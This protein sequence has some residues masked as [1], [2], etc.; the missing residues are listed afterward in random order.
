MTGDLVTVSLRAFRYL[1]RLYPPQFRSDYGD[2]ML[3]V[4]R[5]VVRDEYTQGGAP[6]LT[7]LWLRTVPDLVV[8]AADAHI[9]EGGMTLRLHLIRV[10]ALSGFA[11][12]ALLIAYSLIANLRSPG[13]VNGPHRDLD[14]MEGWFP[15]GLLL[16]A[17]CLLGVYARLS[18]HWPAR[19][20]LTCWLALAG[21]A[22]PWLWGLFRYDF[23]VFL[24][25]YFLMSGGVLLTGVLMVRQQG[26]QRFAW[27]LSG[28]GVS[29]LLF[30]SEDARV[31]FAV[32]TGMLILALAVLLFAGAPADQNEPP[33]IA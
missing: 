30:N 17:V 14:D 31:L 5:H 23:L 33:L 12:G 13:I 2:E 3:Y 16:F 27:L 8:S 20:K 9:Q 26:M 15:L 28:V 32:I 1:L 4:F 19:A 7:A 10:S 25:G 24:M 6:S 22:L 11:S 18:R 21:A 29:S